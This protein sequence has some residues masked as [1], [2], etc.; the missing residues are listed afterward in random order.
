MSEGKVALIVMSIIG[1][2]VVG[3][4]ALAMW[5]LPQYSV[6]KLELYG[7]A[8]LKQAEWN[9]Q[10]AVQEANA[11]L[12]SSK[13]LA[14]AEVEKAKGAAEANKIL[15]ESLGGPEGYLRWLYIDMLNDTENNLIYIPTEAGLPILEAGK[16]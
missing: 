13:L 15:Q 6:Y 11:K 9:R 12:E 10:V 3:I 7:K 1:G 16:R 14:Q 8:E 2:L 4:T 5:G